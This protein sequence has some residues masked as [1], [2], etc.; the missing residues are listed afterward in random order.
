[1]EKF[2]QG[3]WKILP[4]EED[5]EYI[6]IRGTALSRRYKIANVID[7]KRHHDDSKWCRRE[8][9]ESIA[10]ANLITAAPKM[11]KALKDLVENIKNV[12]NYQ[13]ELDLIDQVIGIEIDVDKIE[14]LLAEARGEK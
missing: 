4:F 2:T 7:L 14:S 5:R 13:A 12:D 9:E 1:M 3:E 8:R 10:N 6:R 11:Y